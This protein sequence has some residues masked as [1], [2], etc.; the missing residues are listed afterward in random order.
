[1]KFGKIFAA[2]LS[3]VMAVSAVNVVS[4][5]KSVEVSANVKMASGNEFT[6]GD[7][8]YTEL[9]DGTLRVKCNN[10]NIVNAVVPA[11]V[12][13]KSVVSV[14]EEAFS[15]C[16]KLKSVKLPSSLKYINGYAFY[17]CSK[18]TSVTIPSKVNGIGECA[19]CGCVSLKTVSIPSSVTKIQNSAFAGCTSLKSVTIP[20]NVKFVDYGVFDDCPSLTAINVDKANKNYSSLNGVFY[21]KSKTE[22]IR[23][24]VG[25]KNKTVEI[26]KSVK[27]IE[28]DAFAGCVNLTAINVDKANKNYSSLNG[29]LFDKKKTTLIQY[30]IGSKTAKYTVPN[31]TTAIGYNAFADC[32]ALKSVKMSNGVKGVGYGAFSGCVNLSSVEMSNKVETIGIEAFSD[33]KSLKSMTLPNSVRIIDWYAFEDCTNLSWV[34]LPSSIKNIADGAFSGCKSLKNVYYKGTKAQWDK[35]ILV[36]DSLKNV[37]I[38]YD[39]IVKNLRAQPNKLSV[40]LTWDKYKNA[41]YYRISQMINGKWKH[42]AVTKNA[43]TVKY[44]VKNLEKNTAYKFK[45][46]AFDKNGKV[47]ARS[48]IS[49]KTKK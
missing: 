11:K 3:G 44:M 20:K 6:V 36:D 37:R 17:R 19:F 9:S 5:A 38:H 27:S 18:L 13:G 7:F 24:P 48:E 49:V 10:K 33:C 8:D 23:Y 41:S 42:L 21:D 31:G 43:N 45:V 4:F 15:R 29:V 2:L 28:A 14:E 40:V 46:D 47:I 25:N 30:P 35:I 34:T 12:K 39:Y 22:L 16:L 1:M 32:T 26:P